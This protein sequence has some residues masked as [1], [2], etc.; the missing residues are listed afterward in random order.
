MNFV[1]FWPQILWK[2]IDCGYLISA[3]PYTNSCL[4]LCN[5]AHLFFHGLKM[6]MWFGFN[7]AINFCHFSTLLTSSFFAGSTSTSPKFHLYF[8]YSETLKKQYVL[9][10]RSTKNEIKIKIPC[11][12]YDIMSE[13]C[14]RIHLIFI[15][16]FKV[17]CKSVV[18]NVLNTLRT[19]AIWT[20]GTNNKCFNKRKSCK[21]LKQTYQPKWNWLPN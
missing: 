5:F 4:S 3:T 13:C 6:C 18:K 11:F 19:L 1:I 16:C 12:N 7:P 15:A 2:C 9:S 10:F 14:R 20:I 17:K 8:V 21:L